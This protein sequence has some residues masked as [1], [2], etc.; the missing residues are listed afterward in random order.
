MINPMLNRKLHAL[1]GGIAPGQAKEFLK[2]TAKER[3]GVEYRDL[4]PAQCR[5]LV[6]HLRTLKDR[7]RKQIYHALHG[8]ETEP[9][10]AEQIA[11]VK[12]FQRL[13]GWQNYSMET[14][15]KNRYGEHALDTMPRWK[16]VRLVA[17]LEKRWHNKQRK[18]TSPVS[19]NAEPPLDESS[20]RPSPTHQP[21]LEGGQR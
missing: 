12:E 1:A 9:I 21:T 13:L 19:A 3:F 20:R 7:V 15:I 6:F 4:T 11:K 5:E 16:A 8:A 2:T 10:S 18:K 14:L 17:Y